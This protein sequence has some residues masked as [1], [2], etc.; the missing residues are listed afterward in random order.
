MT[1]PVIGAQRYKKIIR[2]SAKTVKA[3]FLFRSRNGKDFQKR[4]EPPATML[5]GSLNLHY[6]VS[7]D[8]VSV[9]DIVVT[10]DTHT[11]LLTG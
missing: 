1:Y 7:L 8:D 10:G 3:V 4:Q 9:L 11:A 5:Q 6:T 2:A